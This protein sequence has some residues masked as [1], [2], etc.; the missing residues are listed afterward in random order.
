[1]SSQVEPG[2]KG[3]EIVA[4]LVLKWV[5]TWLENCKR[6]GR[7]VECEMR[8]EKRTKISNKPSYVRSSFRNIGGTMV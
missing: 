8:K 4:A 3:R 1:M 5:V 2:A 6:E 7:G